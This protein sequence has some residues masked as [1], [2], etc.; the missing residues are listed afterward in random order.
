MAPE[1]CAD[2]LKLAQELIAWHM[3]TEA[4]RPDLSA[5]V[6][7]AI[8]ALVEMFPKCFKGT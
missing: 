1:Y 2:V 6:E 3:A 7:E 5:A 8:R 4:V